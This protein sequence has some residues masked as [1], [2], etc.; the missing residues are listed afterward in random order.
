M[1]IREFFYF[2]AAATLVV[3][4]LAVGRTV[5]LPIVVAILLAYILAGLTDAL[6]RIRF[7][8]RIPAVF[9][10]AIALTVVLLALAIVGTVAI[11]NLRSIAL[12]AP[13]YQ[14]RISKVIA[15]LAASVGIDVPSWESVQQ[16]TL[17][18]MDLAQ[19]SLN[20]LSAVASA[21][22]YIVLVATYVVFLLMER[23][24][25]TQKVD[26]VVPNEGEKVA[27]NALVSRINHQIVTYL[28]TKT[29]INAILGVISYV[30]MLL[31]GVENAV[32]WA[33]VIAIFNYI[34]YVGSLIGVGIVVLYTL[35]QT[36]ALQPTLLTLIC[37]ALAQVYVGNWLEPRVMSRSLNLSPFVVLVA[38]VFWASIWGIIGAIIAV[39]MTSVLMIVLA[40]FDVTRPIP[41]LLSRDGEI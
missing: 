4:I 22:G 32:F 36:T 28:F 16:M 10:Y 35:L 24:S 12:D 5:I 31:L 37:L 29:M 2:I 39:P 18:R 9:R 21:G 15:S 27:V 1:S 8:G 17:D 38:L 34:P 40:S 6:S 19:T 7:F 33:F 41:V 13:D 26:R 23:V 20:I 3:W 25:I 14:E 30:L 11:E